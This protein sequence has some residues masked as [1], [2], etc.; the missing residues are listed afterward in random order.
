MPQENTNV[1]ERTGNQIKEPRQYVVIFHNDDFT[2]MDFVVAVLMGV[3]FKSS[4]EAEKLMLKVHHEGHAVV[5]AYSYDIAVSKAA[6]TTEIARA[7]EFPLRVSVRE[8]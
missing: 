1:R 2:P 6:K 7:N 3:F 4:D 8:A 5:G